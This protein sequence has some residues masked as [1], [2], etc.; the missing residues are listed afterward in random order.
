LSIINKSIKAELEMARR[1]QMAF[2]PESFPES[3]KIS[4]SGLYIPMHDLGGDFYDVFE[5]DKNRFGVVMADVSGHGASASLVTAMVKTFFNA[6]TVSEKSPNEIVTEIHNSI[7]NTLGHFGI[8]I[9]LIYAIIDLNKMEI[10]Y[11]NAGHVPGIILGKNNEVD[12]IPANGTIAGVFSHAKYVLD[13]VS[14]K[15]GDTIIL[16]TDGLPESKCGIDGMIGMDKFLD[17]IKK[18]KSDD[19][20]KMADGIA[21]DVLSFSSESETDDDKTLLIVGIS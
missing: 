3:S 15:K 11:S 20:K 8:F 14:I 5:L 17:I 2:M 21:G 10:S 12:Y 7:F 18:R 16:F 9:T 4:F 6:K 19:L 1:V 13:K